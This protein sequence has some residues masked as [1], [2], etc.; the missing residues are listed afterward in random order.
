MIDNAMLYQTLANAVLVSHVGIVLFILGGLVLT[1]VGAPLHWTWVKNFWFRTLHIVGI[2]YIAMEAWLGIVCPL[3]TLELWLR[4]KAGQTVYQGDFI[5]HWLRQLMFYEAPA[6]VFTAAYSAFGLLVVLS[7][8]LV[9]PALP[10][11][12]RGSR[13]AGH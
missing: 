5:A 8:F 6:W 3:T 2:A 1:F 11:W 4:A 7:W 9:R 12:L 10:G 13:S